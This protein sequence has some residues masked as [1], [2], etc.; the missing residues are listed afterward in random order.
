M[1]AQCAAAGEDLDKQGAL[2]L[3]LI[4]KLESSPPKSSILTGAMPSAGTMLSCD[5]STSLRTCI[6]FQERERSPGLLQRRAR[7]VFFLIDF[8]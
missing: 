3:F 7:C 1:L 5:S 4:L 2:Q 6:I 8:Y